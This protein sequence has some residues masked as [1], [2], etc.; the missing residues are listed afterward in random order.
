MN[1]EEKL[2]Q[3]LQTAI[4]HPDV[5]S[6]AI[7]ALI[8]GLRVGYCEYIGAPA[9]RPLVKKYLCPFCGKLHRSKLHDKLSELYSDDAAY[10]AAFKK[11]RANRPN[12]ISLVYQEIA[13]QHP[14]FPMELFYN[15]Q[16][17]VPD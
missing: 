1:I 12:S 2:K 8:A 7:D 15:P 6:L 4:T 13:I 5:L 16:E 3:E 14:G 11:A 9:L 10:N 17:Y